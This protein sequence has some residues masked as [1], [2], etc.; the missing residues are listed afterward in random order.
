MTE[1]S[2]RCVWRGTD[3]LA[4]TAFGPEGSCAFLANLLDFWNKKLVDMY[5]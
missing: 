3:P 5:F 4:L 1:V 2:E